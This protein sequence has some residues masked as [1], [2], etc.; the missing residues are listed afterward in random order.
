MDNG[1]T[2]TTEF[3]VTGMGKEG[4]ELERVHVRLKD[5]ERQGK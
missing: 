1:I 2:K 5:R 4:E 3:K